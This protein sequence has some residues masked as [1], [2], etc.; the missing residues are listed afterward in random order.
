MMVIGNVFTFLNKCS[1][2]NWLN[3]C[4]KVSGEEQVGYT[5]RVK[6]FLNMCLVNTN[7]DINRILYFG[8]WRGKAPREATSSSSSLAEAVASFH[9][10][11]LSGVL[12]KLGS[13]GSD[14]DGNGWGAVWWWCWWFYG[15]SS[16]LNN[17]WWW[18]ILTV[19]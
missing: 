7:V 3:V 16:A 10:D 2:E 13:I 15:G 12:A 5:T 4:G 9:N 6:N 19:L 1:V 18:F 17:Q 8:E 11:F 14:A